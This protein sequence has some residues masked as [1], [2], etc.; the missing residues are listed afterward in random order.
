MD[1]HLGNVPSQG[2]D[3]ENYGTI[4]PRIIKMLRD[5]H[6]KADWPALCRRTLIEMLLKDDPRF[7]LGETSIYTY[8][9]SPEFRNHIHGYY[10]PFLENCFDELM[11]LGIVA[12]KIVRAPNGDFYP[13]VIPSKSFGWAY[14]FRVYRDGQ[15]GTEVYKLFKLRK[16]NGELLSKPVEDRKVH[17]F[18]GMMP[19]P[20]PTFEGEVLSVVASLSGWQQYYDRMMVFSMQADYNLSDP[21]VLVET[22]PGSAIP[23]NPEDNV[24]VYM[25]DDTTADLEGVYAKDKLNMTHVPSHINSQFSGT[26]KPDGTMR[27]KR[28]YH[29]NIVTMPEGHRVVTS[30][31]RA[32]RRTDLMTMINEYQTIVSLAYGVPRS[33]LVQDTSFRTAGAAELVGAALRQ[34]LGMWS[35]RFSTILTAVMRCIYFPDDCNYLF[36]RF[37]GIEKQTNY[38]SP[39]RL[40]FLL[41]KAQTI[42]DITVTMPVAPA[43]DLAELYFLYTVGAVEW[44]EFKSQSRIMKGLGA[45]ETPD[46]QAVDP[47]ERPPPMLP[48]MQLP[49]MPK[50]G[51][52]MAS[53][54]V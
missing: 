15:T 26:W 45:A 30:A 38:E 41:E 7:K 29:N 3:L 52:G 53:D 54:K 28:T 21:T 47:S 2:G 40:E 48:N 43:V 50:M 4:H 23:H 22:T 1:F 36:N 51:T 19:S 33:Y 20:G 8:E 31:P 12:V 17:V 37:S 34:T 18:T 5:I 24:G 16:K 49:G 6:F 14:D 13:K 35:T 42:A 9:V 10:K 44:H 46:E 11:I 39:D 32:E 25:P 27:L